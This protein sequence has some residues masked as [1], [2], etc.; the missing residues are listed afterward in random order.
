MPTEMRDA[1]EKVA[2]LFV[3][4]GVVDEGLRRLTLVGR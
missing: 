4:E 3:R 1:A 2:A